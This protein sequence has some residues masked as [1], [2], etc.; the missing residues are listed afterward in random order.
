MPTHT[1]GKLFLFFS[2]RVWS[3]VLFGAS[4][5]DCC[6]QVTCCIQNDLLMKIQLFD[7]DCCAIPPP[8]D[9]LFMVIVMYRTR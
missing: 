5:V 4:F 2:K 9:S 6:L 8:A 1:S 3:C 7:T